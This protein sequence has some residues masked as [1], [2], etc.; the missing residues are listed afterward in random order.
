MEIT[1]TR[2]HQT[3]QDENCYCPT[4]GL[5]RLVYA[6]VEGGQQGLPQA[7]QWN[8][9]VRDASTVDWKPAI[10]AAVTL[11]IPAGLL[12]SMLSPVSIFGLFLMAMA[13]AW[14]VVLYVRGQR[15][16]WITVGAG[17]RI[18]LVTGLM[19]SWIAAATTGVTLFV[20]RFFLHQGKF[21]DDFW[22]EF[23]NQQMVQ[24]WTSMGVDTS[25]IAVTRAWLLAPEGRAGS[26]LSAILFLGAGL[27][28]FAIGG[29]ALG[30]RL[31]ARSRRPEI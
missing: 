25:T 24:Q 4:C 18:G 9:P 5:P 8:E 29:G 7:E 16:A 13:A 3:V 11:A 31:L 6:A 10:R 27:L 26:M 30:A 12:C 1:C 2:C 15:P 20:M 17:A 28:F 19:G 14:T 22:N 21:F 23:V